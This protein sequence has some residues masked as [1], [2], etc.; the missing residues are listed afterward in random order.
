MSFR[1]NVRLCSTSS[2]NN[3]RP[4]LSCKCSFMRVSTSIVYPYRKFVGFKKFV[5]IPVA[6]Q[7]I[8]LSHLE[9]ALDSRGNEFQ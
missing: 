9:T 3:L 6:S 4:I 1:D 7:L 5:S 8:V 2:Q